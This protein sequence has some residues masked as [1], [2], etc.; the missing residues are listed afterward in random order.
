MALLFIVLFVLILWSA[1]KVADEEK[2]EKELW[3]EYVEEH[4]DYKR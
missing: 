4:K 1:C 3:D 2:R